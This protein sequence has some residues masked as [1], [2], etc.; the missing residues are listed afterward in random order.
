[1]WLHEI[2][3]GGL[4]ISPMVLFVLVSLLLTLL[5]YLLLRKLGWHRRVWKGAWFYVSLFICFV[6]LSL[7]VMS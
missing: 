3:I 1:M 6:A 5:T 7:G 2:P 4:L